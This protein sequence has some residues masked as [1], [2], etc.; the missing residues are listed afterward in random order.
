MKEKNIEAIYRLSPMQQGMLFHLVYTPESGAYLRQLSWPIQAAL[1][2]A[3]LGEAW[4]KVV[5]RHSILRSAFLW[6]GRSEPVQIV[7][8]RALAAWEELDWRGQAPAEQEE[9]LEAF[10]RQDAERPL[11]LNKAPVMRLSLIRF[12]DQSWH[13]TWTYPQL[14]LDGWSRASVLREVLSI[15]RSLSS[16]VPPL[17]PPPRPFRDYI[18][19]LQ[20]QDLK[21]AESFWR[22]SLA[23][24]STPAPLVFEHE[25]G[26]DRGVGDRQVWLS[27][28]ATERLQAFARAHRLTLN[29]VV[30]GSWTLLLSRYL[31]RSEVLFGVTVS[32]R[33]AALPGVES[34]I[35]LFINTLPLRVAVPVD[36]PL[37]PW[38]L[39]LQEQQAEVRQYEF[40]PLVDIQGWSEVARGVQLFDT[41]FVF[42]N[43][44]GE[45]A[46]GE[47]GDA[48]GIGG[49]KSLDRNGY[50]LTL[51][52]GPGERLLLRAVHESARFPGTAAARI[53]EHLKV[54]LES[55]VAATGGGLTGSLILGG[56]ERHQ[57]LREWNDSQ[58]LGRAVLALER[59]REQVRAMPQSAALLW[60]GGSM[61]YGELD[62]RTD[63]LAA[64]LRN[65]G[66]RREGVVAIAADRSP[67][68]IVGLLAVAKAGGAHLSL[69]LAY[70]AERL[71]FQLEDSGARMVLADAAQ[72][73]GLP[74]GIDVVPLADNE[75]E[76]ERPVPDRPREG[77]ESDGA[78]LAY[79]IYTSGS[80]GEPK[81]VMVGQRG[82]AKLSVAQALLL[83]VGSGS[84]VLQLASPAFDASVWEIWMALANGAA[85]YL[86]DRDAV[87]SGVG[88]GQLLRRGRIS[89]LTITPS[90][91]AALPDQ[92]L[93][94]L[95]VLCS[96]GE[97]LPAALARLWARPGRRFFNAYGPTESTVCATIEEIRDPEGAPSIGRPIPNA[98]A[99][100]L[101]FRFEPVPVGVSGELFLGGP[102]LARG[103]HGRPG[104][105]AER[106]LPDPLSGLPGERLYRTGDR[107]YRR[108]DGRLDFV[109]RVD[110]QVKVRGIR[111][112]PGEIEAA[113]QRHPEVREAAVV[114]AGAEGSARLVA[115]L[116]PSWAPQ[117][118]VLREFL[119]SR[120]PEPLIPAVFLR[121]D[122]LPRTPVGKLDRSALARSV[123]T[124]EVKEQ[125]S[126]APK[127]MVE[128]VLAGIWAEVLET[129]GPIGRKDDF[130]ERGGH[131]L[132]AAQVV[133]RIQ[134]VLGVELPIHHLFEERELACLAAK[135]EQA[136]IA[137]GRRAPVVTRIARDRDLPLSFAQQRLWFLFQMDPESPAYNI[138]IALRLLGSLDRSI[139]AAS[140]GEIVRRHE[141]LRTTFQ[142][143]ENGAVQ[144]VGPS[145]AAL[146]LIDL[147][148]LAVEAR[149]RAAR[150][151]ARDEV[152][153]PVDLSRDP[154]LHLLLLRLGASENVLVGRLHHIAGDGWSIGVLVRELA[155]LYELLAEG[156]P[157]RLPEL[158]IQYADFAAWQR[159]WLTGEVLAELLAYWQRQLGASPPVLELPTDRP[160]PAIQTFRG[161]Y[162]RLELS[163]DTSRSLYEL[164]RKESATPFMTLLAAFAVLLGRVTGI[165]DVVL[166]T[167]I[168]GR[169]RLET[170]GMVGFFV[171]SLALRL[172]LRGDPGFRQLVAQARA[173]ALGAYSH[174]DLPFE[175]LV[176]ALRI[177]R[178]LSRQPLFQAMLVLQNL[179]RQDFQLP[180]LEIHPFRVERETAKLDLTL[181]LATAEDSIT[182]TLSYSS[183]LFDAATAERFL[184]HFQTLLRS[185]SR[186]PG[187]RISELPLIGES[188][189]HQLFVEW[190]ERSF[191]A[192][193]R[194]VHE[195][196]AAQARRTPE[197][198]ALVFLGGELSYRD[199]DERS[200]RLAARLGRFGAMPGTLVGLSVDRSPEMVTALL[201][202]LKAGCSY[203]PLDPSYPRQRLLDMLTESGA[204]LVLVRGSDRLDL[205]V[206]GRIS[207][208][209]L[210]PAA[211]PTAGARRPWEIGLDLPA[212]LVYTSGSTGAS[213]GI[214]VSHRALA[215]RILALVE[216]YGLVPGRR[217]LQFL[218][219]SFDA[220]AEEIY[221]VLVSGGALVLLGDPA[222]IPAGELLERA[223]NLGADS[224]HV[225][226]SYW[227]Q[228]LEHLESNGRPVP[229]HV[230]LFITG[231]ESSSV[232]KL[233]AWRRAS[234]HPSRF[235]NAYGPSEATITA[236]A[237]AVP[238]DADEI[239][240][241][242]RVPVGGVLPGSRAHVLGADGQPLPI[243]VPGE[244][245][246]GGCLAIG[247]LAQPELT[248]EK[249][250]PDPFG[251]RGGERLYR[252]GDQVR[253]R[254]D[255]DLDL[256]GRIDQQVQVRGL[257]VELGEIEEALIRF[258]GVR[259]AAVVAQHDGLSTS[260][261][262]YLVVE[263][264]APALNE[265]RHHLKERLPEH[266][267]PASIV[268][269]DAMPLSPAGKVDRRALLEV[270]GER[271]E[272]DAS[273]VAPSLP[274]EETLA[275]IWRDVLKLTQV[276]IYD[277]FFEIG[278]DSVRTIQII[279]RARQAGLPL[280]PRDLFEHQTVAGLALLVDGRPGGAGHDAGAPVQESSPE[281]ESEEA[282]APTA[283][284]LAGIDPQK[285]DR[286]RRKY[287]DPSGR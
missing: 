206:E 264:K 104:L 161:G 126:E 178:D 118:S 57:L 135:I 164:S 131:S 4:Q 32:G 29:T 185:S 273:F 39:R 144:V 187:A 87:L 179:P 111:I 151:V 8:S 117:A 189:Q 209:I 202:I 280:A 23:D 198:P 236:T 142:E 275:A 145:R 24:F 132:L 109:G 199:L 223:G 102:N 158:P 197:A 80:T 244:L 224:F 180:G 196:F 227:Y 186:N 234:R 140:L 128:E 75:A 279:S 166:G 139:L 160:R 200:D 9:R 51:V 83:E 276:G 211:D 90:A 95:K 73:E 263:G 68:W 154:V 222:T 69:D 100:V 41:I 159:T 147:G 93:P 3:A 59:F 72:A 258:A 169:N 134:E 251:G 97:A 162:R 65:L 245:F 78:N 177:E 195:L 148:G 153:H 116:T 15:Y 130:F 137:P 85:L 71:R 257:R 281:R 94:D 112:E 92:D 81:G 165:E 123:L 233:A 40:S 10:L 225:P 49:T 106:F 1:D 282:D 242:S 246:L 176:Q 76:P 7:M 238:Q 277:N 98:Q 27:I 266:M 125:V 207:L 216:V 261:V 30:L 48:L 157:A 269:V 284:S 91:L 38:L 205:A 174:Q 16:G 31:G 201:G 163:S 208:D 156:R 175:L 74:S 259:H 70:P 86:A 217:M 22:Q 272:P 101:D 79:L 254:V 232:E 77:L 237:Y 262:G 256:L 143:S 182:G 124:L 25:L 62:V 235:F 138:P 210:D 215:S 191:S 152:A 229:E 61:S 255:G 120:L 226:P 218:S 54:L 278:G 193:L 250:V 66:V 239:A 45:R 248:A 67:S 127:T 221:P 230:E 13:L 37:V 84:R 21:Q 146:P 231:G 192:G 249:F 247:Y 64:R 167:P 33:P 119:A 35:G 56:A 268:L 283:F 253:W 50:P 287:D 228:I 286:L 63:R 107:A 213:K 265:L 220:V 82:L 14:L 285:L 270:G 12:G 188:E 58:T 11:Q 47:Q 26:A 204:T 212:Y 110:S 60:D 141:V 168:A 105:T 2:P 271:L 219:L 252:T 43:Y 190:G 6:E 113:L 170:E 149:H 53:L 5:D 240:K 241:L 88:L 36:E 122:E 42:E 114:V 20:R 181:S 18:A 171:N 89:H 260:L 52:V 243:G 172:D 184:A 46:D 103:Y 17:L 34:M 115:C 136:M 214:L 267:V 274:T 28:E 173:V 96:A 108:P 183:D 203:L 194:P 129:T 121:F 150:S 55:F 19:W 44:L 155:T 99:H 133:F